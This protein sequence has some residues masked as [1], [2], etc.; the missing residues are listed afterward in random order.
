VTGQ[1]ATSFTITGLANGVQYEVAVGA[2]DAVGNV[3]PIGL[4]NCATPQPTV[5]FPE[6]YASAGGT[7]GGGFCTVSRVLP[8]RAGWSWSMGSLLGLGLA[9]RRRRRPRASSCHTV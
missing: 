3:G 4:A 2:V 5:G 6:N 1:T 7:A 8:G 9:L